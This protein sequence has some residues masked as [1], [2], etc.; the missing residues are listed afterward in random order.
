MHKYEIRIV[1][2]DY[3]TAKS[4]LVQQRN[5]F[6]AIGRACALMSPGQG[7]EVWDGMDCIYVNY[8]NQ[9]I[10]ANAADASDPH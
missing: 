10:Y 9:P 2:R 7:V 1:T 4:I 8:R 6:S 3:K 5:A